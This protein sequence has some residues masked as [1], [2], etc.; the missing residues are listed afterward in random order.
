MFIV[1]LVSGAVAERSHFTG[2]LYKKGMGWSLGEL[3]QYLAL[4]IL[5][6]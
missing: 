3:F 2:K 4:L 5:D 6:Y 1:S